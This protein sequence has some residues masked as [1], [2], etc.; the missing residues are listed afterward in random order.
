MIFMKTMIR[1]KTAALILCAALVTAIFTS[2]GSIQLSP[3]ANSPIFISEAVSSNVR[4]L[5]HETLGTPDWVELYNASNRNISLKGY[6]FSDNLRE[7]H[8]WVFPDVTI[9]AGGYLVIYCDNVASAQ[10]EPLCT[11]FG[12][13]KAGET[14]FLS[15]EYYNLLQQ[16]TLPELKSDV[17]YVMKDDFSYGYCAA[18]TPGV[19]NNQP[20]SDSLEDLIYSANPDDL[21]LSEVLPNNKSLP[22]SDG[23]FYPYAELY[24][25]S[26]SPLFLS[27]YYL[28][29]D[30]TNPQKWQIEGEI[31]QP[32]QY[33]LIFFT[34]KECVMSGGEI[35]APFK[36][37]T[38]DTYLILYDNLLTECARLTWAQNMPEGVSVTEDGKFTAFPTPM[39]ENASVRFE[40]LEF[41]DMAE[42][43]PI[44]I[45]EV[46]IGNRYG[47]SD[48]D[49]D[50]GAWVELY[51]GS[52]T[53]VSL[54]G[55]YLS[56]DVTSPFKWAL[57]D[58]ELASHAYKIVFL[59]GNDKMNEPF[60]SSF[61]LSKSD[62]MLVLCS[63]NGLKLDRI[64]Y[65]SSIGDDISI[66]RDSN[67]VWKYFATPTPNAENTTHAFE[68]LSAV[69]P[70]DVNGVYISEVC[71]VNAL[72]SG[73]DDWIELYN[74]S[75]HDKKL[76][77]W[78]LSD[79]P[80]NLSLFSLTGVVVPA[81]GYT[82]ISASPTGTEGITAP[83][84]VSSGG[85]TLLLTDDNDF[86][87]DAF[88]TGA[89]RNGVTSGRIEGDT[90]GTR[91][92]F[93]SPTKK[94]TNS[95]A[96]ACTA[97]VMDPVFSDR[98]LYH[99]DAF[100]LTISSLTNDADIYYTLDGSIPT[101]SSE[102]YTGPLTISKST[103]VR[104][105]AVKEG[106]LN[107]KAVSTT[108][109]FVK[110]HTIPVVCLSMNRSD[111]DA[112]YSVIDR[113]QKTERG[114]G[115]FEYYEADGKLGTA[116][117]CGLRV[118]GAS[119]LL[120]RQKS[121]SVYFRGS[122]GVNS[123]DY[124]FFSSGAVNS[125]SSLVLRN[126]GQDA[127]D[128]RIADSY[129]MRVVKGLNIEAVYTRP[130]AVYINGQYWGLYDLNENQNEDYLAS[131][132]GVNPD[133][134][135]II[136]RN[137]TPLAGSR[138]DFKRVR[139]Y[140]LNRNTSSDAAY[141]E[142]CQW[143]DVNYFNDYLIS[144]TYFTNGDMF[145]Q[146]YWR[147]Q[148]YAI[149]WRPIY[150]DLDLSFS[151][152]TRNLLTSY[153]TA[154]GIPSRDGTLTNMD[155][156]VGLNKNAAWREQ[157]CKRYVYVVINQFDPERLTAILDELSSEMEPEMQRHID[158]WGSPSS[159]S[160]WK[161][162]LNDIRSFVQKRPEYA[163]KNLRNT[164]GLSADTLQS[165]IDEAKIGNG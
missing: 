44:R 142:L 90:S 101:A 81:N 120:M 105:I 59:S 143:V 67:G 147:S 83:F 135:D 161:N 164:F 156:F 138:Y 126:S 117:P 58:I 103:P 94:T 5:V 38:E 72:K 3:E 104:A 82:V 33:A 99:D 149:K 87:I 63:K 17:S 64:N 133:K 31:L 92:F 98:T 50:R 79:D 61:R 6:G 75:D 26:S 162:E 23:G 85:E 136:R 19:K 69:Q 25:S 97:Y 2:C 18:P 132:Y 14:L 89:L 102:L 48:E 154:E 124:P 118:S 159:L 32:G 70:I 57:P 130:V 1:F 10:D 129:C 131:Y 51:N 113:W 116:L 78:H 9:P 39:A 22:S 53:A 93:T 139:E 100:T 46:L 151:S 119:T 123:A 106:L 7:P 37:G 141:A 153:F 29:D 128:A 36:L 77:G 41:S 107:S 62:G 112:V 115:S 55:Y 16:L 42:T 40:S 13:S 43:D 145:N 111:F 137:E 49:G 157:F 20:I 80:D 158:R 108:Y 56:D 95:A 109:L 144:Q 28:T 11:G 114:G 24:N 110:P 71:A 127:S 45:N 134:V 73:L 150:F 34:G 76:D 165:Y 163:L 35:C 88:E 27:S 155:I 8:K 21:R 52:D 66:G 140:A 68:S 4:S 96:S 86:L 54:Y 47:L 84:S 74:G 12:L 60:H 121:L 125:Y 122:Y 160:R 148:D 15:D 65:E 152:V 146:K 30:E 91:Y